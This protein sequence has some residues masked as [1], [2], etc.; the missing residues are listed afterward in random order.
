[1]DAEENS[2]VLNQGLVVMNIGRMANPGYL[3]FLHAGV[4]WGTLSLGLPS[5][6]NGF[7]NAEL[8]YLR[9]FS[10]YLTGPLSPYE[11]GQDND[12]DGYADSADTGRQS[13]DLGG[14]EIRK[15]GKINV[16]IAPAQVIAAAFNGAVLQSL[17]GVSYDPMTLA[18]AIVSERNTNG[19]FSS[20]DDL[21]ERVPAIFDVDPTVV[22]F[23]APY[24][25]SFR[26]EA[27]AR[28]MCNL[29]T[30]RTDVWGV[31]G[32]AQLG[33]DASGNGLLEANEVVADRRFYFVLDRSHDPI[34]IIL[35]RQLP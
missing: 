29:V 8:V 3:G 35:K 5:S 14:P 26:R 15:L 7:G 30:V 31:V 21:F 2:V 23:P 22:G 13:G 32:R 24:M 17:R 33:V 34:R 11:D 9:N 27:L 12:R 20:V 18:N 1:V 6:P 19:P 4:A 25:N 28:F 16:N 10:D